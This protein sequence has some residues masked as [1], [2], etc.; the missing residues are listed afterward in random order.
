MD[1]LRD[2]LILYPNLAHF[3]LYEPNLTKPIHVYT[4]VRLC[5]YTK[6]SYRDSLGHIIIII[7]DHVAH[8]GYKETHKFPHTTFGKLFW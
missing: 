4:P 1:N 6:L 8:W 2:S 7:I 5:K 3:T